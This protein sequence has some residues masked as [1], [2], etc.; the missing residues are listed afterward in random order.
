MQLERR[1]ILFL[2]LSTLFCC[3]RTVLH[4]Q[5]P[6]TV[7][8]TQPSRPQIEGTVDLEVVAPADTTSVRFYLDGIQ[9][10]ELTNEY[11]VVTKNTPIW[12]TVFA[13]EWFSA[14]VHELSAIAITPRGTI[15]TSMHVTLLAHLTPLSGSLDGAWRFAPADELSLGAMDSAM[16]SVAAPT[17]DDEAWKKIVVPDSLDAVDHSWMRTAGLLG[18]YRR[19]FSMSPD[20]LKE[21]VYLRSESCFWSCRY[22]INGV[23]V[24]TSS[25]GYLPRRIR[26]T[27]AVHPGENSIAVIVDSRASTMGTFNRLRYYYWN[28][29]GLLQN[30]SIEHYR[31]VALTEF[32]AQGAA[33]GTLTVYPFTVNTTGASERLP[34]SIQVLDGEGKVVFSERREIVCSS[35][36]SCSRNSSSATSKR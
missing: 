5:N 34:A 7:R 29:S 12:H 21:E 11:A 25:G 3:P 15:F 8:F 28:Y 1:H 14:G 18:T 16:P 27:S 35:R 20:A 19:T 30:I 26:I 22:F 2:L 10:S 9:L 4:A 33:N 13:A 23:Q 32:R 6:K 24:G 17:F 36:W 31:S